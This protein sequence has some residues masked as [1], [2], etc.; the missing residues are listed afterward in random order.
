MELSKLKVRLKSL[1][2]SERVNSIAHAIELRSQELGDDHF[3]F[4]PEAKVLATMDEAK[5][6]Q[7]FEDVIALRQRI[8]TDHFFATKAILGD[9]E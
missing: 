7:F 4:G 8:D 1:L 9:D 3:A 2:E 5:L 6:R